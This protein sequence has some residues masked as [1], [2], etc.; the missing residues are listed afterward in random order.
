IPPHNL[1]NIESHIILNPVSRLHRDKVVKL[2][3]PINNNLYGV[4]LSHGP[5]K[6]NHKVHVNVLP[7][8]TWNFIYL[9]KATRLK[10]LCLNLLTIRTLS[11]II[12]N[13]FL[14]AIPP[15]DLL[16]VMIHPGGTWMYR[17]PVTMGLFNNICPQIIHVWYT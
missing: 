2:S 5:R 4:I 8:P 6:T 13:V 7:L 1:I 16:E 12:N 11:H 17:I 9:S 15:V 10:V 14:H 3:H